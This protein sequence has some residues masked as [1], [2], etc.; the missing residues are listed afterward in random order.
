MGKRTVKSMEDKLNCIRY[1]YF[2]QKSNVA[3]GFGTIDYQDIYSI[4]KTSDKS[5]EEISKELLVLPKWVLALLK[6][7]NLLVKAFGL[8]TDKQNPEQETFFTLIEK[9]EEEI[10]MGEDDKHLN[11]RASIMNDK[12]EGAIYLT[13]LVHF[14]NLWGRLYF[15]PVKPFH[16]VI[17][18]TL[19]KRYL[20]K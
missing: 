20:R 13:T 1:Y 14:N 8:K 19:L 18:K 6:L 10:I 5:A 16:K 3:N 2:P 17:M 15:L 12:A 11:F 4:K 7:R 9:N